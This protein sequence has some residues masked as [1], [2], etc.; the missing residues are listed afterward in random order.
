MNEILDPSTID[1]SEAMASYLTLQDGNLYAHHRQDAQAIVDRNA[2]GRS[3]PKRSDWGR[4]V[5]EIPHA[6][7]LQWLYEEH[8]RGNTGLK[9]PSPEFTRIMCQKVRAGFTYLGCQP[10]GTYQYLG[11]R[12]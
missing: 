11:W 8:A 10:E 5:A 1:W 6:V 2:A 3:D 7:V 12:R 4:P 9:F